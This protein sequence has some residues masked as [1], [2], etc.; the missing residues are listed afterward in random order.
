MNDF[1]IDL[2]WYL[3]ACFDRQHQKVSIQ[4]WRKQTDLSID[5]VPLVT[6]RSDLSV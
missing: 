4:K 5:D 3:A 2:Q 6:S 1:F